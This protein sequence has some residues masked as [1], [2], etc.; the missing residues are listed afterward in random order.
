MWC[1]NALVQS[2]EWYIRTEAVCSHFLAASFL[3][4][5]AAPNTIPPTSKVA[6]IPKT[7][8]PTNVPMAAA[9]PDSLL[10]GSG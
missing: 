5:L 3:F 2:N 4:I 8:P 7:V 6:R 10:V 9:V 1:S